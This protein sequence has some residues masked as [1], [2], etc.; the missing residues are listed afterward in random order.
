[1]AVQYR[2]R[3]FLLL[4]NNTGIHVQPISHRFQVIAHAQYWSIYRLQVPVLSFNAL[5]RSN[6]IINNLLLKSRSFSYIL[7]QTICV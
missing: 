6:H 7:L 1:M 5:L 4:N 2:V 3:Y